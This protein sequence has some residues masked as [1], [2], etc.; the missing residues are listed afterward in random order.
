MTTRRRV[1]STTASHGEESL[2]SSVASRAGHAHRAG[3]AS[4]AGRSRASQGFTMIELMVVMAVIGIM[5]KAA[6]PMFSNWIG[7]QRLRTAA[8]SVYAGLQVARQEAVR[9]N[10]LVMFQATDSTSTSWSVCPVIPGTAVCDTTQPAVQTRDGNDESGAIRM[11]ASASLAMT[12]PGA[13]ASALA[14]GVGF[15]A[16][17]VFDPMGRTVTSPAITSTRRF[18]FRHT[19]LGPNERRLVVMVSAAG[20]PRMCDPQVAVG[21][22]RACP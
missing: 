16:A 12:N 21:N 1:A 4:R 19:A 11:G 15:P 3:H 10:A 5:M 14:P 8:E 6:M 20:N 2:R 13:A 7:N 17:V 18:D 9:R 22:P